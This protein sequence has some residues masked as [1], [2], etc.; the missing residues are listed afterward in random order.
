MNYFMSIC[1]ILTSHNYFRTFHIQMGKKKK[2]DLLS[3]PW[4]KARNVGQFIR[5]LMG[6]DRFEWTIDFEKAERPVLL[7]H[8]F[9]MPRNC[10][11]ILE[12]RLTADGYD[13]FAFRLGPANFLGVEKASRLI[14]IKLRHLAKYSGLQKIAIIGHS[15]GGIIGRAY[16]SLRKG[17]QNCHTLI[18]LGSPHQGHPAGAWKRSKLISWFTDVPRDMTP[19]SDVLEKLKQNPIP[20]TVYAASLYSNGDS[21]CPAELCP[22]DIPADSDHLFNVFVKDMTHVD[23]MVDPRVYDIIKAHL[24]EGFKRAEMAEPDSILISS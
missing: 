9:A 13:V 8:G 24:E 11:A 14:G 4:N 3:S 21:I 5:V 18:T 6:G 17:Q 7:I 22:L 16:V 19:G 2:E 10:M 20:E 15:L 1:N 23:L 12:N